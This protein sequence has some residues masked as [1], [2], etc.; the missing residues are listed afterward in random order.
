MIPTKRDD[1]LVIP[2]TVILAMREMLPR[3][4]KD[5]VME[6]LGVSSNTWT[7]IKRG[8]AIRRSTGERLLQRFG[9]DLPRA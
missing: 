6:V 3:Q 9:H 4:S 7:K 1:V 8:E 2:P 5:C